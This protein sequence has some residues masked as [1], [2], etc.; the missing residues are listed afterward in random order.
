MKKQIYKKENK[1]NTKNKVETFELNQPTEQ[2]VMEIWS[3]LKKD[4]IFNEKILVKE[5]PGKGLGVFARTKIKQGEVVEYCHLMALSWKAKYVSDPSIKQYAYWGNCPCEDCNRHG[6]TGMIL[7]GSGSIYNSA[8]SED[9]KNVQS[10][11]Y[12]KTKA[13]VFFAIKDVEENE[14]LLTWFGQDY[15]NSWCKTSRENTKST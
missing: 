14:E 13:G 9:E 5:S 10:F 8:E 12:P 1:K 11:L 7:F 2:E 4:G 6:N 3:R 15:Y